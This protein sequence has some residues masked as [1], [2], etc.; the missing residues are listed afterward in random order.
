MPTIG[1]LAL[2][3]AFAR[4]VDAFRRLG[5]DAVEVRRP[6]ELDGSIAPR[7]PGRRV[8]DDVDAA[9]PR[10]AVR[11]RRQA[12]GR[13]HARPRHLRG[14]DPARDRDPRRAARP[15]VLRR[16]RHLRAPQRLRPPGRQL[17]SRL[18]IGALGG[19]DAS[20][21]FDASFIRA[22]VVERI[23]RRRRRARPGRRSTRTL[24]I[25]SGDGRGVPSGAP[26]SRR[27]VRPAHPPAISSRRSPRCPAIPSGRR[28]S[29]RR[30]PPTRSGPRS[31]PS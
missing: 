18:D 22:P 14:D 29:T 4:H 26:G 28:S 25:R 6:D 21:P 13:R 7:H 9:R 12:A 8:G 31:S 3:G 11:P 19:P 16:H 24:H 5:A 27:D 15:A 17:R 20:A 2:Q 23:G 10:R 1:V 30:R